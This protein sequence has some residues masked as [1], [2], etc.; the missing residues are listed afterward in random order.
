M[1]DGCR[2]CGD[3]SITGQPLH[4]FGIRERKRPYE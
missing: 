1:R 2:G 3:V 4:L